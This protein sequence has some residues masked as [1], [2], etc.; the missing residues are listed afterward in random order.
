MSRTA[1]G[2]VHAAS[3][4]RESRMWTRGILK[5]PR[6][7]G[8]ESQDRSQQAVMASNTLCM[9]NC[10]ARRLAESPCRSRDGPS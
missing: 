7:L 10:V 5:S 2:C 3:G 8:G 6:L 4:S 1:S 9:A